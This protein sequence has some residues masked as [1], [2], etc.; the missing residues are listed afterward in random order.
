MDNHVTHEALAGLGK[1]L[2]GMNENQQ[3]LAAAIGVALPHPIGKKEIG[4]W[5]GLDRVTLPPLLQEAMLNSRAFE[6]AVSLGYIRPT[7]DGRL[8]WTLGSKTLLAYFLG[9]LFCGD[10]GRYSERK[11]C[12]MWQLGSGTFPAKALHALFGL[13]TLFDLRRNR[14]E[15]SLPEHFQMVDRLFGE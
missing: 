1:L 9:R 7:T 11:R 8:V 13:N 3:S 2:Q 6:E 14:A 5:L 15:F 4:Y 12:M 10:H